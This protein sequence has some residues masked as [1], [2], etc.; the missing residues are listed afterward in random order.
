M[1]G[2]TG[3]KG[4]SKKRED[5]KKLRIYNQELNTTNI[6]LLT[7]PRDT[8]EHNFAISEGVGINEIPKAQTIPGV[9]K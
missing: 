9:K 3:G 1:T 8:E 6:H 4:G 5:G 2:E 7:S